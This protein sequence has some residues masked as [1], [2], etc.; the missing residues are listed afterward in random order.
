MKFKNI[1][2]PNGVPDDKVDENDQTVIGDPNP[3]FTLG[4]TNTFTYKDFELLV[5]LNASIGGD[6]LNVV[7]WKTEATGSPWDNQSRT[8]LDRARLGYYDGNP[9]TTTA[10]T[11]IDN[12]YLLN[13]GATMP[14]YS[15]VDI[16]ANRRMSDRWI[17]D[18]SY[19]RIQNIRLS[20]NL[21]KTLIGKWGVKGCKVYVNAQNVYT[22]TKYSGLDAEIGAYKQN[23]MLQNIDLGRY[24]A[25]R[26]F[27]LG[28]TVSF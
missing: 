6:I 20:Y 11:D 17:E 2:G 13:P 26:I 21:P 7:R 28:A 22:F 19:L 10:P 18:G 24:P 3:D 9:W 1:S 25:P 27:T 12:A 14:R 16:N 15:N 5:G 4:F 23:A 8:V